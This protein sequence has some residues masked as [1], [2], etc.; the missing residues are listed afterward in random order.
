MRSLSRWFFLIAAPTALGFVTTT[1]RAAEPAAPGGG[2]PRTVTPETIG[3]LGNDLVY[4]PIAACRVV[5]TRNTAAG[6]IAAGATR[7]FVGVSVSTF[8][9]QGGSATNCGTNPLSATAL[10]I[11]LTAISPSLPGHAVVYPFGT[12]QPN[13]FSI[14]YAAGSV[15][16]NSLTVQIPN[17]IASFDFTIFT[18]AQAHYTVDVVG[19]LA[20]PVATALQCVNTTDTETA[21]AA[22]AI[23]NSIALPCPAGYT[24]TATNC[25]ASSWQMPFAFFK[26]GTCSA[27]NNSAGSATLRSSR[28]C[29]RIPGR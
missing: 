28:T 8:T 10:S 29:C 16:S 18:I 21:V 27:Q 11:V 15:I 1:V 17:P 23:A 13:T 2:I 4:T 12:T 19:F 7:S 6:P 22:G 26:D 5:D 24:Q 3:A 20:P 9:S 25:Q 14:T